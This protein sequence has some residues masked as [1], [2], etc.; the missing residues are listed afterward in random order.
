MSAAALL[1]LWRGVHSLCRESLW[2]STKYSTPDVLVEAQG[3]HVATGD[4]GA[5][6]DLGKQPGLALVALG[7][8]WD[9]AP[10]QLL[11]Q[12]LQLPLSALGARGIDFGTENHCVCYFLVLSHTNF[13]IC[14]G[15]WY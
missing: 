6:G 14:F 5:Q 2:C 7:L 13:L 12:H 1:R 15:S 8:Q 11:W 3:L 9:R 10:E 4:S